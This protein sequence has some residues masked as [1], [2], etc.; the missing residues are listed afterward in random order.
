MTAG[1][2]F[3]RLFEPLQ[4]GNFTVRNRIV[5]TAHH[6]ALPKDREQSYLRVRARG[7]AGLF[8]LNGGLGVGNYVLTPGAAGGVGDWDRPP[9]SG[10]TDA[11]VEFYDSAFI[12]QL[13]E[14]AELLHAEGA[15]CF[16]QV[17]HVGAGQHWPTMAGVMGPSN[18]PDPYDGL[19]PHAMSEEE[20]RDLIFLFAQGIRRIREAGLDAAEIHGAHGYLVMQFFSPHFNRRQDQWGGCR[21]NRVRFALAII[22]AARKLVGDFPIGI[23]IGCEGAGLGRGLT[24]EELVEVARLL[25]PHVAYISISNG[26]YS[27]FADGFDGAY[28]SPWYREPAFNAATAAAVRANVDVPVIL[29]GRVADVALAHSL[30]AEGS[31]DMIGMVR[32]LVADPDLP[33]KAQAGQADRIRMC[34]G[35]SECH[36][37]GKNR[38]AMTCAVNASAGREEELSLA[39]AERQKT[40]VVVGA[41][42]AGLEAARVAALRGHKVYLCDR[43]PAIGGTPRWLAQDPNRRNLRDHAVWFD[44]E[45]RDLDVELVLGHEVSAADVAEF[46]ADEVIIA[47]GA[48]P[49]RPDVPGAGLPHVVDAMALL[50]G[51][52]QA[53]RRV[54]VVTGGDASVAAPSLADF[55]ADGE[56]EVILVSEQVDFAPGVEDGTRFALLDRLIAK[57]VTIRNCTE[58]RAIDPAGIDVAGN[59]GHRAAGRI[60]AD[61]VVLACGVVPEDRLY[62]ELKGKVA[63][64]HLIGDAM[65][66]R[67]IMHATV[68]GARLGRAI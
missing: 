61:T 68:E 7:G 30:V 47:T 16:G 21:E 44:V 37:I 39:P 65:A 11:G 14:K 53:G 33:A 48:R 45:L 36:H 57:G 50:R 22:A 27:G 8:G 35:M 67:R 28:V 40:V 1:S 15:R 19:V 10:L 5:C 20:I 52:A 3:P 18:V 31:A 13:R 38:V 34:L 56:R 29:T 4:I 46:G 54:V 25:S 24:R 12:P 49:L 64:L 62:R 66:P 63:S 2:H 6:A 55:L 26:S 51:E 32:A 58:L 23:R 41:G 60:E 9:P 59:F 42:P 43:E 17:N